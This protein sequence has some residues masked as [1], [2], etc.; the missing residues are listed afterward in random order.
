MHAHPHP[1][2]TPAHAP[3]AHTPPH[4]QARAQSA[5]SCRPA[6][7]AAGLARCQGP[8]PGRPGGSWTSAPEGDGG[9]HVILNLTTYVMRQGVYRILPACSATGAVTLLCEEVS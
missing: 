4:T 8:E 5:A 7:A 1:Q 2:H 9:F 6:R 3:I